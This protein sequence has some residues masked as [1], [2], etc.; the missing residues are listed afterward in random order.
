M[1][2]NG[3]LISIFQYI[4]INL[5]HYIFYDDLRE[6]NLGIKIKLAKK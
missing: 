3:D 5:V 6:H 4:W 2:K 1:Y